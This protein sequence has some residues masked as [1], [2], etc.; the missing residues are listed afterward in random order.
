[1]IGMRKFGAV[2]AAVIGAVAVASVASAQQLDPGITCLEGAVGSMDWSELSSKY[3]ESI[4]DSKAAVRLRSEGDA[5]E[6]KVTD[7]Y[8][9]TVCED[10]A[11]NK[12][13][14][15]FNF[16]STYA[17]IF[18][19]RVDNLQPVSSRYRICAE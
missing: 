3:K 4:W 1:M 11:D 18:N 10:T 5:L 6:L 9:N 7:I 14:C 19:I 17:G 2:G 13:R 12:T 15:K 16:P 8:G